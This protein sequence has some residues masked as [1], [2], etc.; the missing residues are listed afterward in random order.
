[1]IIESSGN[2]EIKSNQL[3]SRAIEIDSSDEEL[4]DPLNN[5]NININAINPNNDVELPIKNNVDDIKEKQSEVNDLTKSI[6]QLSIDENSDLGIITYDNKHLPS[7]NEYIECKTENGNTWNKY[8]LISH[9][10]KA[11]GKYKQYFNVL[12]LDDNS[13]KD[14]DWQTVK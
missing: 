3:K 1:M 6:S 12:N 8:Q 10:G 13:V 4:E 2:N 9:A 7:K 5:S 14:T 11:T